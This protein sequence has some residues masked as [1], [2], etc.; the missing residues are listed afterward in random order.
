VVVSIVLRSIGQ[1]ALGGE[2]PALVAAG[3]AVRFPVTVL[4]VPE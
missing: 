4:W 2:V 1:T 3:R